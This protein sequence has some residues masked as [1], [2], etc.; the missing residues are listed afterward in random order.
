MVGS[1]S[2][3]EF[4][5]PILIP[6]VSLPSPRYPNC[7]SVSSSILIIYRECIPTLSASAVSIMD[8][9]KELEKEVLEHGEISKTDPDSRH[10]SISNN[11]TDISHNVQIAVDE[12]HHL[13]T[14]VEVTS[15]AADNGQLYPMSENVKEDLSV[16]EITALADKGYYNGECLKR[17]QENG[18]TAIVSRQNPQKILGSNE[19]TKEK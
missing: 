6:G 11:G 14:T 7:G 13:V 3:S 16:D 4:F 10:M 9:L 18:I 17:C 19:F 1:S 2:G 8:E 5:I 12:K 15:C